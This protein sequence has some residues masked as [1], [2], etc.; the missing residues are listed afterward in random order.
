MLFVLWRH[1]SGARAA[2]RGFLFGLGL[3]GV[4]VSWLYVA[5][6]EF[7][8][9]PAP[10]AAVALLLFFAFLAAYPALLGWA[11]ARVAGRDN[12]VHTIVVL[13]CLWVLWEWVRGWFLTGFPWLHLGY[14]QTD[15][16][17]AGIA[18]VA[19]VYGVSLVT[20]VSAGL[21]A[22][23]W[24]RRRGAWY[25]PVAGL[26]GLW[27]GAGLIGRVDWVAP[28]GAPLRVAVVQG[29]VPLAQK[30]Y[31][32]YRDTI[33][34]R[35]RE[36]TLELV[37]RDLVIWPEAAVPAY[38]DEIEAD[39]LA[40]LAEIVRRRR[41]AILIGVLEQEAANG[42]RAYYN[43]A[44]AVGDSSPAYRK[45]HLVP[46]GEFLPF[47]AVLG[48]LLN[49]LHIPMSDFS[50]GPADQGPMRLAGHAVGVSICYEFAF[51]EE[52]IRTLPAASMLVNISEDAW[53]GDS[54][55]PHQH[56]QMVRMR[57]R[58]TGRPLVRA[59]NTGI[60]ALIDDRGRVIARAP[61]FRELVLVGTLQP[62]RG[63]TPYVRTG[64]SAILV[65]ILAGSALG[66]VVA[67]R[68]RA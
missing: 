36:L 3:F 31:P 13:P 29:N 44:L 67:R 42:G 14:S 18:P 5:L 34:R 61:Q 39:Y 64:N 25:W 19:G 17:L 63:A 24:A 62:M 6:H 38:R 21:L 35:Y 48:G 65:V 4:G 33:F 55:A 59:T 28:D 7:G 9:M 26:L 20:A 57:A 16:P 47:K 8:N 30:W 56:Q 37:D 54:F 58:E 52:I 46:F 11:Q 23:G 22:Q 27:L 45:H 10:L 50:R 68:R 15:S 53:Y 1:G 60:S 51:G 12:A 2:W 40:G 41:M 49:Y 43:S 66:L 32:R